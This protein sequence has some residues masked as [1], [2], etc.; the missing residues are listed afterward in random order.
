MASAMRGHAWMVSGPRRC[1]EP[2]LCGHSSP[3]MGNEH[4]N[5]AESSSMRAL[6]AACAVSYGFRRLAA[7]G[8]QLTDIVFRFTARPVGAASRG[9]GHCDW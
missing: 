3:R 8:M 6:H 4:R 5:G 9:S 2:I 7:P 1:L